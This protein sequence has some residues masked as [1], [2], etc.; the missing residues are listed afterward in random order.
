M[1][2]VANYTYGSSFTNC[3]LHH[4]GEK[5]FR[6]TKR[7]IDCPLGTNKYS[8]RH[9]HVNFS[10]PRVSILVVELDILEDIYVQ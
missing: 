10:H 6:S 2:V 4:E 8:H 3:P 1:V 7:A 9:D 5:A